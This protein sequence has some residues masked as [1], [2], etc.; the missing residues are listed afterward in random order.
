MTPISKS[1]ILT[2]FQKFQAYLLKNF[3]DLKN[4]KILLALSGGIDSSV[5]L[6]LCLKN[7][8]NISIAH[9]NFQ[10]RGKDSE[11]DAL[12]IKKLAEYKKLECHI[13]KFDIPIYAK[14]RKT[15]I[16]MAARKLRYDWFNELSIKY[17]YEVILV[18]HHADDVLETFM[19]NLMR[20]SGLKGLVGIPQIRGKIIRPL[21]PF[22][23]TEILNYANENNIK[24]REDASNAKTDYLRNELRHKVIPNWKATDSNFHNQFSTTLEYLGQ[25]KIALDNVIKDFKTNYFV[26]MEQEIKISVDK[27]KLLNP[28][29]FLLHALFSNYGFDNVK[30][31]NQLLDAQSGK[32]LFSKTH[33]LVKNRSHLL[34]SEQS[35]DFHKTYIIEQN[36]KKIQVPIKLKLGLNNKIKIADKNIACFNIKL[37]K[38]PL[39]LRKWRQSDYFYPK[40]LNGKKKLSKYFKD[41]KFSLLDKEKQWLLCSGEDIIW[42][43]GKRVDERYS[44]EY[45]KENRWIIRNYD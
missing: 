35:E 29:N 10:L 26:E 3:S 36:F 25:A 2:M 15:S 20:G 22:T 38:F 40:G 9:C 6:S 43:V 11:D 7:G 23:R 21:L 37:L 41:E 34:L 18:A 32:Q 16:Q 42:V 17:N 13:K 8:L 12:W 39:T 33:R 45:H 24:W 27:L 19:I 30:D 31:L 1:L 5:L 4:Q 14:N 44:I 28:I